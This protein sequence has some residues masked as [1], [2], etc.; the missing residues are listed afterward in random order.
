MDHSTFQED[1]LRELSRR[2]DRIGQPMF[3][4]FLDLG[5]QTLLRRLDHKLDTPFSLYGGY[6]DAERQ[7]AVFLSG[8]FS[9]APEDFPL[10][11]LRFRPKAPRFASLLSHRDVLGALMGLQVERALLGDIIIEETGI[12]VFAAERLAYFLAEELT[13]AGRTA[14][15]GEVLSPGQAE[16]VAGSLS[17]K[18]AQR[19][20]PA[21]VW[22]RW[23]PRWPPFPGPRP[24]S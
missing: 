10:C 20:W 15:T 4:D 22:T 12:Y 23:Y 24:R 18:I 3:S 7:M 21:S 8:A 2:A 19:W 13:Q 17:R 9:V 1:R 14:L 6:P 11:L 16:T 5:E